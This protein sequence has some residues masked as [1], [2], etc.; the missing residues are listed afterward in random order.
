MLY[1]A[2]GMRVTSPYGMRYHPVDGKYKMHYGTD[3]GGVPGGFPIQAKYVGVV[4]WVGTHAVYGEMVTVA[5]VERPVLFRFCHLKPGTIKVRPGQRIYPGDVIAGV[6]TSGLSTGYHL[7]LEIRFDNGTTLGGNVWGDP[8][9]YSEKGGINM[10]EAV[11]VEIFD[12]EAPEKK[13]L[14]YGIKG[15]DGVG[16]TFVE[17]RPFITYL[18]GRIGT[19]E[20]PHRVGFHKPTAVVVQ[21]DPVLQAKAK[22]AENAAAALEAAELAYEKAMLDLWNLV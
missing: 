14:G 12:D 8:A 6:G 2:D 17:L 4:R 16:R 20:Y 7:H 9:T 13:F 1:L 19:N 11:P 18:G 21:Y 22:A 15:T 3:L 10:V 5:S